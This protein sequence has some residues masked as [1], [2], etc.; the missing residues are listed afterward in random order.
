LRPSRTTPDQRR[1]E[2]GRGQ[3]CC[4]AF[5]VVLLIWPV[6]VPLAAKRE[7]TAVEAETPDYENRSIPNLPGEPPAVAIKNLL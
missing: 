2:R 7:R 1:A 3:I 4:N 5:H 6:T